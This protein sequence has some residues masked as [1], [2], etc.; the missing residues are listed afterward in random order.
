[1]ARKTMSWPKILVYGR[2]TPSRGQKT[3]GDALELMGS[4]DKALVLAAIPEKNAAANAALNFHCAF[5]FSTAAMSSAALRTHHTR[6]IINRL[7]LL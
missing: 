5:A 7:E 4:C 6:N 3:P 1:M 2:E